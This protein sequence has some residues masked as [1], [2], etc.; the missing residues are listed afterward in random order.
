M[1]LYAN[2]AGPDTLPQRRV[3]TYDATKRTIVEDS[4]QGLP[5]VSGTPLR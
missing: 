1:E 3:L 5:P 2:L 4:Y